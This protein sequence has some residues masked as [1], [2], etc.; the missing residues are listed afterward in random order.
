M[1]FSALLRMP[2]LEL[3]QGSLSPLEKAQVALLM[4]ACQPKVIV[5][6]GVWRGSTT[7]FMAEF[8]SL[9]Q[10]QGIVYAFDLSKIIDELKCD[11]WFALSQNVNLI[12]G[13]LPDS[14]KL[15]LD[16]HNQLIDFALVDAYHS[17]HAVMQELEAIAP[18]LSDQGYIFC[19]DYGRPSSKYE[20][21]MCAVNQVA[22]KYG[23]AVLPFWS[24]EEG[25]S[26]RFC[27]AAIL[28]REV[29][30]SKSRKLFHWRKYFAQELPG[31]ASLWGRVRHRVLG[32]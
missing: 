23:L 19:H 30:C 14:L 10:I 16:T 32:D 25:G 1:E 11:G 4:A 13:S 28:R 29:K 17:F 5:E 2:A 24:K 21:V 31:L 18:R 3:Q 7:R 20:G 12:P 6:T 26:E 15:W 27:Q 9:N 8:L 22:R